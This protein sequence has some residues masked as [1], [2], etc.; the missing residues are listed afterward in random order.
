MLEYPANHYAYRRNGSGLK[1]QSGIAVALSCR[2]SL[3]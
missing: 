2:V 3:K 1:Q